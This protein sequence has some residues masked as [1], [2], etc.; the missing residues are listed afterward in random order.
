MG[1]WRLQETDGSERWSH[2]ARRPRPRTTTAVCDPPASTA[3]EPCDSRRPRHRAIWWS[4]AGVHQNLTFPVHP[5]P[6][7]GM[8]CWHQKVRVRPAEPGDQ[9]G[10]IFVDFAARG[11]STANGSPSPARRSASCAARSGCS[12]PS[13]RP[14]PP[15]RCP[16]T[17]APARLREEPPAPSPCTPTRSPTSSTGIPPTPGVPFEPGRVS[18]RDSAERRSSDRHRRC[19]IIGDEPDPRFTLAN[20]RTFPRLDPHRSRPC[21]RGPRRR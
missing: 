11:P 15:T 1:R 13:S 8:H 12:G 16:T 21:R 10:D 20:E 9:Y 14:S 3:C 18:V 17:T 6:I 2:R 5:D 19:E 4:D 7:S